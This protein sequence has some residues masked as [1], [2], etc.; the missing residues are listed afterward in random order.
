MW[1]WENI[2][3]L[4]LIAIFAYRA[5]SLGQSGKNWSTKK[6]SL[7]QQINSGSVGFGWARAWPYWKLFRVAYSASSL[8]YSGKN[9]STKKK[10][11]LTQQ[12]NSGSV[13]FGVG[14]GSGNIGRLLEHFSSQTLSSNVFLMDNTKRDYSFKT[15]IGVLYIFMFSVRN[16]L[17]DW[18]C[19]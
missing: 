17:K 4:P 11:S 3:N 1:V 10:H 2:Y 16:T 9:W 12:I 8:G 13:G 5:L 18:V 7:T 14:L 19:Y 15:Q 6:H